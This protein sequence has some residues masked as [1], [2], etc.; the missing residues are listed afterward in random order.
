MTIFAAWILLF[1]VYSWLLFECNSWNNHFKKS[2][3]YYIVNEKPIFRR[4]YMKTTLGNTILIYGVCLWKN[5]TFLRW[6]QQFEMGTMLILGLWST[7]RKMTKFGGSYLKN[8]TQKDFFLISV[9]FLRYFFSKPILKIDHLV[10]NLMHRWIC[11]I[12]E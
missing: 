4:L 10:N 2:Y 1:H 9:I 11:E 5:N 8:G 7:F 12:C 6:W 3:N